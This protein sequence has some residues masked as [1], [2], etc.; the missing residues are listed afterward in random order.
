MSIRKI[1]P[2]AN[3]RRGTSY[4]DFSDLTKVKS[5]KSLRVIIAKKAGRNNS[6]KITL[7]HR[8]GGA[9][10]FYRL[11]NFDFRNDASAK[12]VAIL[13]DPNRSANIALIEF[14]DGKQEYILAPGR[15]KVG[16]KIESGEKA[17][18]RTGSQMKLRNIPIGTQVHNIE[19]LPGQGGKLCRSA[20]NSAT[21][22]SVD[23]DVAQV[24][25]PSS[26]V[27]RIFADC[28]ASIGAVGNSDVMNV[29]IGKAGRTRHMRIR[30][31]VRGKAKNAVD[32]PHGGG[33]GGSPIGM[34]HPKT[35]WGMPTLGYRTRNKLKKSA[36]M[37]INR[38]SK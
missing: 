24:K 34:P 3:G 16:T 38:R 6:G 7:A 28:F 31:T 9:K 12:V 1:K 35:P 26:E 11:V 21:L 33:E 23:G 37:I 32:H 2:V 22:L 15:A 30:P 14:E 10:R 5:Q 8:G 19:L 18:V 36:K 17:A 25:L 27:R 4:V 29:S 13:Y 20:G